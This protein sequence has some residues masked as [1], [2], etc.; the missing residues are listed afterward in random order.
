MIPTPEHVTEHL[1]EVRVFQPVDD[2]VDGAVEDDES[3]SRREL[4]SF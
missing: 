2:G 1:L 4:I 3:S